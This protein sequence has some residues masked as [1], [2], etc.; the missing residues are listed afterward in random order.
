[1]LNN[2]SHSQI[3]Q[4]L[5][6][7]QSQSLDTTSV[8]SS[9]AHGTQTSASDTISLRSE[10]TLNVTY[11]GKMQMNDGDKVKFGMLQN[12]VANLLKSTL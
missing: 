11:S 7:Y 5:S 2:I 3:S 6:T 8:S 10:S 1:M 12:L 9:N 4:T